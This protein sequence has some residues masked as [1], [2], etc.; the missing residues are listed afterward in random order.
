MPKRT[1]QSSPHLTKSAVPIHTPKKRHNRKRRDW[2]KPIRRIAMLALIVEVGLL[3][4][5]NPYLRVTKVQVEGAQSLAPSQIFAE[6]RVP[7]RTNIFWMAV[8]QP[9]VRR[10][11]A[12]PV[13]ASASRRIKLPGTLVLHVAERKPYATLALGGKYWLL[14]YRGVPFRALNQPYPGIREISAG[15]GII[16]G[17]ALAPNS[18][19]LGQRLHPQWLASAY[20]LI[21]LL[22]VDENL[23]AAKIEVDQNGNLCLNRRDNLRILLGQPES[24]PQKMAVAEAA[25][26][27]NGGTIARNAAYIDVSSPGQPVFMPRLSGGSQM[28]SND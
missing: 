9:F 23:D 16:Q 28:A 15:P 26:K 18:I 13:V 17:Q 24:L 4:F 1:P 7:A 22:P 19:K 14:D 11:E 8:R 10:L 2:N 20:R 21:A 3:L 27:A 25:I 6:A 12:D 5:A